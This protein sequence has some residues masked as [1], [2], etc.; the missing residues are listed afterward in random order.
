MRECLIDMFTQE[1]YATDPSRGRSAVLIVEDERVSRRALSAL[2]SASG[3]VPE[4]VG[5]GEEA[6]QLLPNAPV[7]RIAL[8]DLDLPG[9]NGLDLIGRL[10]QMDPSVFKVL[11]TAAGGDAL[12]AALRDRG[13]AYLRKPLDFDRLLSLLSERQLRH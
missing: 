9:M 4:A 2:L 7:P 13:V 11:I 5:S 1:I 8:I 6:L 12:A 3:Y 10:E